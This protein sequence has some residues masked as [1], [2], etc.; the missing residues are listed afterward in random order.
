MLTVS[1]YIALRSPE[2]AAKTAVLMENMTDGRLAL[3]RPLQAPQSAL[4]YAPFMWSIISGN[5][6]A[7]FSWL[8]L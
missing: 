3:Y 4:M 2:S 6:M 8:N 1:C 7:A 5:N